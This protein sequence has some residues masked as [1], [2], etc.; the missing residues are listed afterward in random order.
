MPAGVREAADSDGVHVSVDALGRGAT[1]RNSVRSLRPWGTHVQA[2]LTTDAERGEVALPRTS[3]PAGTSRCS[4]RAGW[5]SRYDE[6]LRL[7][8]AGTLDPGRLVSRTV[9]LDAV[10]DRLAA[11]TDYGTTGVEVVTGF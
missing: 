1:C 5:P 6:L 2:G 8:S 10:S 7:T 4:D 9:A 11:M 3:S